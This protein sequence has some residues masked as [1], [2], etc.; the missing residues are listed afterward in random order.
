MPIDM[1]TAC[2]VTALVLLSPVVADAQ[3]I[4]DPHAVYEQHCI[5][6][7]SEHGADFARMRMR[8]T[9]GKPLVRRNSGPMDRLL[10][11]HQGVKL[12]D[13]EQ[14]ALLT[15]FVS[16]LKWDGIYQHRCA[17]CHGPAVS[18]ARDKLAVDGDKIVT[19]A[20][21]KDVG[22][23]LKSHGQATVAETAL[24]VEM[25]RFQIETRPR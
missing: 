21:G 12:A 16:G 20:G 24:L 25:L 7:H 6:C 19:T 14:K 13:A 1:K 3:T 17:G 9:D 18:F 2:F 11:S 4:V 5:R 10:R 15:L 22:E 23:F 8:V